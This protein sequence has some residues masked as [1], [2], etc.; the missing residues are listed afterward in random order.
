ML[1]P[2]VFIHSKRGSTGRIEVECAL[3]QGSSFLTISLFWRG[4]LATCT[5]TVV[6]HVLA[7]MKVSCRAAFPNQC[8]RFGRPDT[9]LLQSPVQPAEEIE[10]W[11]KR[12]TLRPCMRPGCAGERV[13][14]EAGD[15]ARAGSVR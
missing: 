3:L 12:S 14:D 5:C 11:A 10:I 1:Q 15:P 9:H 4:F 8:R 13:A 6:L 2:A 7:F